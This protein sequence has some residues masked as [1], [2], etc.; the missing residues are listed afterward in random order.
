MESVAPA[1]T[2][3]PEKLTVDKGVPSR[4]SLQTCLFRVF[5]RNFNGTPEKHAAT[6]KT[7]EWYTEQMLLHNN[8]ISHLKTWS[9][10]EIGQPPLN[11]QTKKNKLPHLASIKGLPRLPCNGFRPWFRQIRRAQFSPKTITAF[12]RLSTGKVVWKRKVYFK[13]LVKFKKTNQSHSIHFFAKTISWIF[14][15]ADLY[16]YI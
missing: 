6:K 10:G 14:W 5:P 9:A 1:V 13:L 3:S 11:K 15:N 16:I 4:K 8:S 12:Q 7:Q 2:D